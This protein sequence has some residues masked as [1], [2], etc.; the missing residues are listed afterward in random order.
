MKK[1]KVIL[2]VPN[3]LVS[4]AC[5]EC[6]LRTSEVREYVKTYG[7]SG[8]SNYVHDKSNWRE[9]WRH[10]DYLLMCSINAKGNK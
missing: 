2:D 5:V 10:S 9:E 7:L 1:I 3:E 6:G 8:L 4:L